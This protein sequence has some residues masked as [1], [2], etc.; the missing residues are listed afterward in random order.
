[1]KVKIVWWRVCCYRGIDKVG[2]G[3]GVDFVGY[4]WDRVEV[5]F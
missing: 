3:E 2:G 5:M 4:G 1:M